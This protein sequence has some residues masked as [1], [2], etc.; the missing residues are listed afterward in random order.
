MTVIK[1]FKGFDKDLK[2]RGF[3]FEVGKEFLMTPIGCGIA[4]FRIE[5]LRDLCH[6][7]EWQPNVVLPEEFR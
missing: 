1:S 5:E 4:G 2:C 3:Q 7:I 6:L